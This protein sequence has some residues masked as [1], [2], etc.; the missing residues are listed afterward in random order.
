MQKNELFA[1]AYTVLCEGSGLSV[2]QFDNKPSDEAR[3]I[4][5]SDTL[6]GEYGRKHNV[7]IVSTADRTAL[8][9]S[10]AATKKA[11]AK[12]ARAAAPKAPAKNIAQLSG[13][14]PAQ[15]KVAAAMLTAGVSLAQVEA[16]FGLA[17]GTLSA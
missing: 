5:K 2:L 8:D 11:Q 15:A 13:L 4:L 6:A 1:T 12:E 3:V 14:K 7:W 10:L 17:A 9:A 16:T